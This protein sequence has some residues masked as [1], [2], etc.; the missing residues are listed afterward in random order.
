MYRILRN[1]ELLAP[2]TVILAHPVLTAHLASSSHATATNDI[3]FE[4]ELGPMTVALSRRQTGTIHPIS[5]AWQSTH[6]AACW[7][8][9]VVDMTKMRAHMQ[10]PTAFSPCPGPGKA[11]QGG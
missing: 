1:D 8:G 9:V 5:P 2:S 3:I 7:A 6:E 4:S 10:L 11:F